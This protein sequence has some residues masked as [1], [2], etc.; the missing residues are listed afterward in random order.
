MLRAQRARLI[1]ISLF[2]L[3]SLDAFHT[4]ARPASPEQT[5]GGLVPVLQ[6]IRSD[7][8]VLTRS[9]TRCDS[10]VDPKLPEA[11]VLYLPADFAEPDSVKQLEHDCKVHVEHLPTV[12]QHP[13]Q[14]GVDTISPQGLLFL[15]NSYVVPGGR[16]NEMYG[17]DSYFIILGLVRDH[18]IDLARGMV[19]NFFFEI[20]HYG[21]VLNANRTYYL[22]RSQPPF[23]TSMIMEVY[24]AEKT[25]GHND[26]DWL[27]RAYGF[28]ARDYEM[29]IHE[30]HLA[31]STG[32]SRYY[33]FGMGPAPES[34]QDESGLRRKVTGYFLLR[35]D[36]SRTYMAMKGSTPDAVGPDY[37]V[38]VCDVATTMARPGCDAAGT[39]QLGA[40][41]YKGDRS[42]RESAFDISFRFGPYGAATH[43]FAPVCLNSLLYKTE[44]DLEEIS[45]LLGKT[46]EPAQ[47]KQ[48]AEKRK[49]QIDKYLWDDQRGMFFD[50][51]L[52]T[53]ARSTYEYVTTFYPLWAGLAS[54][55]QAQA[56]ARNVKIFEQR[57][58][59]ATST[60]NTGMQWDY[61]YGWAPLQSLAVEGLRHY[62]YAADADRVSY[63]FLSTVAENFRREK[64]IR[65]KYDVVTRSS[66]AHVSAGYQANVVGFG[67][68][69]GVFL[70]LL[71][72]LP[73]EMIDRLDKDQDALPPGHQ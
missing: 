69:N 10:V 71:Q 29:W 1:W 55:Q 3:I 59:L 24:N 8:D 39:V 11:V 67:W 58:G 61:P 62:G 28:A 45:R 70:E 12:I 25:S 32:L 18:R 36:L 23:L 63:E 40:D 68:T 65:E 13:G 21:T 4:Y 16:F 53:G 66:E 33:D 42:M 52:R 15:P 2:F 44:K 30:P 14:P 48:R 20:E 9:M 38:Q 19:E 51:D 54:T 43:H 5:K 41:Y 64:T 17:W 47:W 57:G 35:P 6:Y 26:K 56:V 34:L 22:T 27:A 31:E 7:W 49:Q 73:K 46:V 60:T 72:E 50:Y 37:N